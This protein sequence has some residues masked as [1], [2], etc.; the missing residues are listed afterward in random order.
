MT[1][2]P[3][4]VSNVIRIQPDG[5]E[6][7]AILVP[8]LYDSQLVT[9][10][11]LASNDEALL[12]FA[13]EGTSHVAH[14]S[15]VVLYPGTQTTLVWDVGT[16]LWYAPAFVS[17]PVPEP[18]VPPEP[19]P[20]N[21]TPGEITVTAQA[22]PGEVRLTWTAPKT[23]PFSYEVRRAT[24]SG[25]P[26]QAILCGTFAR[27]V[28]KGRSWIDPDITNGTTYYYAVRTIGQ[29]GTTGQDS[30]E[31]KADPTWGAWPE[32]G[33][34]ADVNNQINA[35]QNG[36]TVTLPD[37]I[38]RV[39]D[40][41]DV[42]N[43][44]KAM[45]LKASNP[46]RTV[47]CASRNWATGGE[48]NCT[49][50]GS[51]PWTSSLTP[52][53]HTAN[54]DGARSADKNPFL[55]LTYEGV[56]GYDSNGKAT[57][58]VRVGDGSNPSAGQWCFVSGGDRHIRLGVNPSNF[59]RIEVTTNAH[60]W[61]VASADG[62]TYEGLTFVHIG[63]GTRDTAI[64][65]NDRNNWTMRDCTVGYSHSGG[66]RLGHPTTGGSNIN[67][68]RNYIHH[69]V[70][71]GTSSYNLQG[72][73]LVES[74]RDDWCGYNWYDTM[75]E[76]GSSKFTVNSNPN[77]QYVFRYNEG[78]RGTQGFGL[79]FDERGNKPQC[80]GN[81]WQA[82]CNAYHFEISD[83]GTVEDNCFASPANGW[84]GW[85][86][87]YIST[88]SNHAS[89][90][91]LVVSW[92]SRGLQMYGD[93]TRNHSYAGNSSTDDTM[94]SLGGNNGQQQAVFHNKS[95]MGPF[96]GSKLHFRNAPFLAV[97]DNTTV[98]NIN[99]FNARQ[100]AEGGQQLD[101]AAA[102]IVLRKWGVTA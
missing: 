3:T 44:N 55:A 48:A 53:N 50:S 88:S 4:S 99:D 51:G 100:S 21:P 65:N 35:A 59:Q 16:S 61:I 96:N 31:A 18:P 97:V 101:N 80:Y 2:I 46:G 6:E 67:L 82:V 7:D 8:G 72:P 90:R 43:V 56:V 78:G 76:G 68:Q 45:L 77:G 29:D 74:N 64:G 49:W 5:P 33:Y 24:K 20:P 37:G 102:D 79:W 14:G 10:I 57:D 92:I 12:T 91:N 26:Y 58:F 62:V 63:G 84:T 15:E 89:R 60:R 36:G 70:H 73:L 13:D 85:P 95:S 75:W 27:A 41:G 86:T 66:A 22:R 47:I 71:I 23:E 28:T 93:D 9:V 11:N 98:S 39:R 42:V 69:C 25:G 30:A 83:G 19:E 32:R 34:G 40:D 87:E 1:T 81:R 52:P 38:Y 94:I 17:A 54:E